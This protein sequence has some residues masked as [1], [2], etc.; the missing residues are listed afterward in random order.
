MSERLNR[1]L[2]MVGTLC[3][4]GSL[5][6]VILTSG[7][8]ESQKYFAFNVFFLIVVFLYGEA[9]YQKK[10]EKPVKGDRS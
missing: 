3:G 8:P 4:A 5:L 10:K 7:L 2:A 9:F 6:F 1:F